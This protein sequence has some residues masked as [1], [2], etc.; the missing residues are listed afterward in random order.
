M[1]SERGVEDHVAE[2]IYKAKITKG[3]AD[4]NLREWF[5]KG[6]KA[7]D[8]LQNIK[9][10][11]IYLVNLPFWRF[12]A[13]GKAVA[14][15]YSEYKERTGNVIRNTFEELVDEEF[16]WTECACD[17][18]K[19]GIKELW[20]EPGGEV[21]YV[22]GSAV[23]M[24]AGGSAIE[25]SRRGRKAIHEMMKEKVSK[26]IDT[27]TL[28]KSFIIPKVFE[29]V[30]APVWIVH[31]EYREGH[32][33]AV[34]DGV[35]G[36][37]L[38]GTAPINMTARIRMMIFS[39]TAGAVMI[40]AGAALIIMSSHYIFSEIFPVIMLLFGIA[41]CM[42]A[43]PAFREGRTS[44]SSGTMAHISSLRPAVRVPEKLT[45]DTILNHSST[46]LTCP[47]CGVEL[48]QPW[49]EVVTPCMK[50]GHL[51]DITSHEV[52]IV[53]YEVAKLNIL[54]ETAMRGVEPEYLPFWRFDAAVEVSD[55]LSEGN[56]ETGLPD[57]SG[58]RSYYI[59]ASDTPR[60]ISEP[61]E[62]DL[63]IR[64]PEIVKDSHGKDGNFK[65]IYINKNTAKELTEFL[66]LRYEI[67]KPGV[68]QVLRYN[69]E[70]K[71]E[72]IVYIPYFKVENK[73]I[74]GV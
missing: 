74:P 35:K 55:I 15:G 1:V 73:Y 44:T 25:A 45:D 51:L 40:G 64:N 31:Y 22:Y 69:L 48:E 62:I 68:L 24:E 18:G 41:M 17:T 9:L 65:S 2:R 16:V 3:V 4:K 13:R 30:Y 54:S 37:V 52:N 34:I 33:S 70:I 11:E 21:P 46:V 60:Y 38:G 61:M 6:V 32:Y 53:Q 20:L 63:T 50:C 59:C 8:L 39:I 66:F 72:K 5:K 19:Y 36:T 7:P 14:C 71:S 43:Y 26:R 57:I 27:I 67:D 56:N 58:E 42:S 29:I 23:T 12:I 28:D 10:N 47:F 49:G